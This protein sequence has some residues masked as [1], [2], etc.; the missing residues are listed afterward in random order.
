MRIKEKFSGTLTVVTMGPPGA[1]EVLDW[2]LALG[3]DEAVLLSDR[4]FAGADTLATAYT[5]AEYMRKMVEPDIILCGNQT[6]DGAT[7]QVAPQIAELLNIPHVTSVSEVSYVDEST[8]IAKQNIEYG[9]Y[10]KVKV[11][12][13]ALLAVVKI[14]MKYVTLRLK[15]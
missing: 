8:L 1:R 9:G 6:E 3:A 7:G 13:P 15:E 2:A 11:K 10:L 4:A 14:S 5:L 12:L